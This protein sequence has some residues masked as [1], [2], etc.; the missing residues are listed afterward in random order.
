MPPFWLIA[1][2]TMTGTAALHMLVPALP[3]IAR[4][5]RTS[6]HAAQLAM[7]LYLAGMAI[8]QLVYGPLSDRF[9]RRNLLLISQAIY[10]LGLL[11]AALATRIE[12]LLAARV[13]QSV[14]A[15]GALVLGRAM[16]RDISGSKDAARRL[17]MLG[18]VMSLTPAIAPTVGEF[19]VTF[20]GWRAI[21]LVMTA[22]VGGLF[23]LAWRELPETNH[24]RVALPGV[25][26]AAA[27]YLELWLSAPFRRFTV[28]GACGA[29]SLYGF[30][31]AA[32]F[33]VTDALHEPAGAVAVFCMMTFAGMIAGNWTAQRLAARL[34]SVRAARLGNTICLVCALA[35]F[36]LTITH[37]LTAPGLML[38]V[39]VYAMGVG[40]L[41]PNALAG[42]MNLHP[43]RAGTAS[44]LY[45]F[46]QMTAG[47][48]FTLL[49]SAHYGAP[50]VPVAVEMLVAA[51]V[52]A[53][54]LARLR[55]PRP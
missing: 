50:G 31:A 1:T 16:V 24:R 21:F 44:S 30:F 54:S 7:T 38:L 11:L 35:L 5:L 47:A 20:L 28:A 42:L 41:S 48:L 3:M 13:V 12:L 36:G 15:C 49:A 51:G 18:L 34:T 2:V 25:R 8:G 27:S 10:V 53:F 9:G 55:L 32:P 45:G 17:A 4:D 40:I 39:V 23:L 37:H 29:T 19:V 46:S 43:E 26:A 33:L 6:Q 22:L 52:A 14:G